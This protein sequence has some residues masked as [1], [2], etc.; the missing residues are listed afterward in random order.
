MLTQTIPYVI[1]ARVVTDL[2]FVAE[3]Q[4]VLVFVVSVGKRFLVVYVKAASKHL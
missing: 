1:I 4:A 2:T 3:I